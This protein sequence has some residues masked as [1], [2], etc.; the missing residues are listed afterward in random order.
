MNH[1]TILR[2]CSVLLAVVVAADYAEARPRRRS[3]GSS[4]Y[5]APAGADTSS[6]QGVAEACARMGRLQHM[7]G[8]PGMMEGLGMASTPEA[9]IR[10]C[11]FYGQ[12]SILD[13]GTARGANGMWYA[14]IRGR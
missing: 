8:H 10:R 13:Q 7:G 14:C 11:C 1:G 2:L 9:A 5:A 6:A 3:H 12:I 4:T